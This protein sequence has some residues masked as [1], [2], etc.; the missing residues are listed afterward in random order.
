MGDTV[1]H[2]AEDDVS[3]ADR[4]VERDLGAVEAKTEQHADAIAEHAE[5][6]EDVEDDT[7]WIKDRL[8]NLESAVGT[9][10]T[11]VMETLTSLRSDLDHLSSTVSSLASV[12]EPTA[13][14]SG[15]VTSPPPATENKAEAK[16]ISGP[17]SGLR[18]LLHRLL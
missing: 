3:D 7:K 5:Q 9:I 6:L 17:F 18:K 8:N 10:P 4:S 15:S 16:E 11:H 13:A 14:E 2:T 12:G 1:I